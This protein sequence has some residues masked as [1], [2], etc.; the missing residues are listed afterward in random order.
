MVARR[1]ESGSDPLKMLLPHSIVSGLSVTSRKVIFGMR[2]MA[3][4]S[5]TVP[6]SVNTASAFFSSFTKSKNPNGSSS[7][8]FSLSIGKENSVNRSAVRGCTDTS[9]GLPNLAETLESPSKIFSSRSRLLV[10]SAR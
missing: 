10:F 5:C 3:H 4:S 1:I 6:L 9:T 2:K 7:Q 8:T